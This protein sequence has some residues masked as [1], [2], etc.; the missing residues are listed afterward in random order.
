MNG[1]NKYIDFNTFWNKEE[2]VS[3]TPI[4]D[5]DFN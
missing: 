1:C 5:F 3:K 4:E 2:I